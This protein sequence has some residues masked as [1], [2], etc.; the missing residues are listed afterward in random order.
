MSCLSEGHPAALLRLDPRDRAGLTWLRNRARFW[1]TA[2]KRRRKYLPPGEP[3]SEAERPL[4]GR[5]W[6]WRKRLA[7]CWG[8]ENLGQDKRWVL[9]G[10]E[11][12]RGALSA[13]LV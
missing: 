6:P 2:L 8:R 13:R 10:L 5:W 4:Y 1:L 3:Y 9:P 12:V 7:G 11:R